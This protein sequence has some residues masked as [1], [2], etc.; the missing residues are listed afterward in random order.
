MPFK[1][2]EARRAYI[3][4]WDKAHRQQLFAYHQKLWKDRRD[5]FFKD[6]VCVRCGATEN[7]ELDHIDAST[8]DP[9]LR[10][11]RRSAD[12]IWRWAEPRRAV[13]L[14]KCQVLC[15]PC[16]RLKETEA[17]ELPHGEAHWNSKLTD[18]QVRTIRA[19]T[20]TQRV[21]ARQFG[22]SQGHI[23]MI[24]SGKHRAKT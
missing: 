15:R 9:R 24:R 23:S 14:A 19:S 13:E 6:K 11:A 12:N 10:Q 1:D 3:R 22:V 7:L 21:L 16:N 5:A 8:K 17:D 18:E 4:K 20:E 2:P